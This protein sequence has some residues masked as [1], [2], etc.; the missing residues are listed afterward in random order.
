MRRLLQSDLAKLGLEVRIVKA[1]FPALTAST[2]T[3]ETT[4]DMWVHWVSTYYV[5]SE[6]W[7]GEKYDSSNCGTWKALSWYK[8]PAVDALLNKARRLVTGI[9]A[10]SSMKR[11]P[12]SWWRMQPTSGSITSSNTCR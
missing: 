11:P 7:I 8:N 2:K 3:L 4:P 1:L 9:S 6:N 5:A 12:G 10:P